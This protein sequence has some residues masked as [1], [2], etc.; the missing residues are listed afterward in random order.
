MQPQPVE[1]ELSEEVIVAE[2]VSKHFPVTTGLFSRGGG[3]PLRA[4]DGVS[5]RIPRGSCFAVVGESGSGKST[6]ARLIVGL[7]RPTAGDIKV[8]DQSLS[9]LSE[10]EIRA[11][12]KRVQLVLQDPLASL[13][14]RM[15]IRAVLEEALQ[16]HGI[17]ATRGERQDRIATVIRQVGLSL[18]HLERYPNELSGG[19]RQRVAIARAIICEPEIL[20]LDEPVSALDVSVQA[21]IINLLMDLQEQLGLTY[22]VITHDLALVGHMADA[23]AVMYLGRFVEIGS[24]TAV[25]SKPHHP[26]TQSLLSVVATTDPRIEKTREVVVL[27]GMVPSP[28]SIPT[29]CSFHTRCP[30]A[31]QLGT[32]A[33]VNSV[34]TPYGRLPARCVT[35]VPVQQAI[36]EQGMLVTC[37]FASGG[38]SDDENPHPIPFNRRK[39]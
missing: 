4:V 11:M 8:D 23:V 34:E 32:A 27:E 3:K 21:Q 6:L 38:H 13:D 28:S 12:R 24:A 19:Q 20:V 33:G 31:R 30:L 16:V 1:T 29:G 10:A 36:P 22:V 2:H 7:L 35:D 17:G 15:R 18:D 39:S 25:S 5:F 26:Y 37:H 9:A 14:P